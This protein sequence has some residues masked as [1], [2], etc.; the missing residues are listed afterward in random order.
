[1]KKIILIGAIIMAFSLIGCNNNAPEQQKSD[2]VSEKTEDK[3]EEKPADNPNEEPKENPEDNPVEEKD[4]SV[5]LPESKGT[6][7]FAGKTFSAPNT[8]YEFLN[9]GTAILHNGVVTY[10][11]GEPVTTFEKKWKMAYSFNEEEKTLSFA[12]RGYYFKDILYTNINDYVEART[13]SDNGNTYSSNYILNDKEFEKLHSKR[14]MTFYYSIDAENK[15]VNMNP[16]IGDS[17]Q[18]TA[19]AF[20]GDILKGKEFVSED[21]EKTL[22]PSFCFNVIANNEGYGSGT[23]GDSKNYKYFGNIIIPFNITEMTD[24]S[25]KIYYFFNKPN[26]VK[27]ENGNQY[28]EYFVCGHAKLTYSINKTSNIEGKIK[29]SITD[30]DDDYLNFMKELYSGEG[31][32]SEYLGRDFS[33]DK[34][35]LL[36]EFELPYVGN[37]GGEF[38]IE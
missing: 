19:G 22:T 7:V 27:D 21:G 11:N 17:I 31:S 1:M 34:I 32:I 13:N 38:S 5:K 23:L 4:F 28:Y 37:G 35:E 6:D 10:K 25:A 18:D 12:F 16:K 8:K 33:I 3:P 20:S 30:F 24:S 14:V 15:K 36:K 9:D 2:P 26:G 29:M